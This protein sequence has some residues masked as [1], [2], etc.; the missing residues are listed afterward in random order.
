MPYISSKI[1]IKNTVHDRRIKLSEL[2]KLEILK[3][4]ESG[5]SLRSLSRHYDVDRFTIKKCIP[6]YDERIKERA[7]YSK[8]YSKAHRASGE[9]W[10]ATMREHQQYKH[11]L[12]LDGKISI[13]KKESKDEIK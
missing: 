1:P 4:Y 12:L 3:R 2:D 11:K 10:N 6:A 5:E 13:D 7:E 9:E 8:A